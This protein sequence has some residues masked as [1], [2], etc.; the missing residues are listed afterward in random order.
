[1]AALVP[2]APP[3]SAQ[4]APRAL[5]RGSP[6][7]AARAPAGSRRPRRK[8]GAAWSRLARSAGP[9]PGT[10]GRCS[11]PYPK[12][13]RP[14]TLR[15][16]QTGGCRPFPEGGGAAH[17]GHGLPPT[18]LPTGA[19]VRRV[20]VWGVRVRGQAQAPGPAGSAPRLPTAVR[21]MATGGSRG[22]GRSRAR[23]L[24]AI[25]QG[26]CGA[27]GR[28]GELRRYSENSRLVGL[29]MMWHGSRTANWQSRSPAAQACTARGTRRGTQRVLC[30]TLRVRSG[31]HTGALRGTQRLLQGHCGYSRYSRGRP[32]R[33][34]CSEPPTMTGTARTRSTSSPRRLA[35]RSRRRAPAVSTPSALR[36][37]APAVSTPSA[38]RPPAPAVSTPAAL[39]PP[40]QAGGLWGIS[41]F[42]GGRGSKRNEL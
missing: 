7:Q 14:R 9:V 20:C 13:R 30:G 21:T 42:R 16:A 37:P 27:P 28:Q 39:R 3:R 34:G 40:A 25:V 8:A 18:W 12:A 35:P 41:G 31:P 11:C 22:S 5:P 17:G 26:C 1:M 29:W 15:K 23:P 4:V 10:T 38:L 32:L 33:K 19:S 6:A 36:P 2:P 24:S